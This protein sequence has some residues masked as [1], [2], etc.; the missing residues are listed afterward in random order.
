MSVGTYEAYVF[1][2]CVLL[3]NTVVILA[4]K[5]YLKFL[6]FKKSDNYTYSLIF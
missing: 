1:F 2:M 6:A 4:G 3:K 5:T